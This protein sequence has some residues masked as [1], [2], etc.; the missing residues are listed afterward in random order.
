MDHGVVGYLIIATVVLA[1]WPPEVLL[2]CGLLG[3]YFLQ[4]AHQSAY[5]GLAILLQFLVQ[6]HEC[7]CWKPQGR[8]RYSVIIWGG[9]PP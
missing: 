1:L 6:R 4:T 2:G 5:P 8:G 7:H 9:G 3:A